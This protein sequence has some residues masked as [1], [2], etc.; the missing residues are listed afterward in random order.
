MRVTIL[1][2]TALVLVLAASCGGSGTSSG[3][4][5]ASGSSSTGGSGSSSGFGSSGASGSGGG[6]AATT[7]DASHDSGLGACTRATDLDVD[8][9][10]KYG[11]VSPN[12]WTC[13]SLSPFDTPPCQPLDTRGCTEVCA[14]RCCPP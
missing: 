7:S 2:L 9:K 13:P 11:T 8:C 5:G 10:T 14:N 6:D 12:G 1:G 3:S 4:S